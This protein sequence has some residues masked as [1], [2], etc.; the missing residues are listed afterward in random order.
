M[1]P[2]ALPSADRHP[3]QTQLGAQESSRLLRPGGSVALGRRWSQ[4]SRLWTR[5]R[6]LEAEDAGAPPQPCP[7]LSLLLWARDP[8]VLAW[9]SLG[10]P[11]LG[12]GSGSPSAI[13]RL[14]SASGTW[15]W[16][17]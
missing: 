2:M 12:L 17:H 15:G 9:S 7:E 6:R 10:F 8:P 13:K 14:N 16:S 11:A 4:W 5:A 1:L 3:G